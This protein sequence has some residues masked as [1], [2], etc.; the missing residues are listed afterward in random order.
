MDGGGKAVGTLSVFS[1]SASHDITILAT[2]QMKARK[3][4]HLSARER[5]RYGEAELRDCVIEL[6]DSKEPTDI[7]ERRAVR[8]SWDNGRE[9]CLVSSIP[10]HLFDALDN[11]NI[12]MNTLI[13]SILFLSGTIEQSPDLRKV[14]INTNT[15]DPKFMAEFSKGLKKLNELKIRHPGGAIY[16]F[17]LQ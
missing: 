15:K 10:K 1:P 16:A 9:S 12:E 11:M 5:Y 17:E 7:Y 8:I 6:I 3:F 13:Q 14:S 2:N 4:K